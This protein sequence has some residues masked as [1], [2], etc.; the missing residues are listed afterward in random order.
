MDAAVLLQCCFQ[1]SFI[2]E[3]MA[4]LAAVNAEGAAKD[5]QSHRQLQAIRTTQV[6][7]ILTAR[8]SLYARYMLMQH[9]GA[10]I[11]NTRISLHL[12]LKDVHC[13]GRY[14][15]LEAVK[16]TWLTLLTEVR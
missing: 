16:L 9:H 5:R 3:E 12:E 11:P 13:L 14:A 10:Q 15:S 8:Q 4:D 2:S 1:I 6:L 7:C